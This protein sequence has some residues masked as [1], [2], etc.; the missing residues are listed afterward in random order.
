MLKYFSI[1]GNEWIK[2]VSKTKQNQLKSNKLSNYFA[3][4]IQKQKWEKKASK[5]HPKIYKH[6]NVYKTNENLES[7]QK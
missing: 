2:Q 1:V 3:E 4:T 5:E 6:L 7:I